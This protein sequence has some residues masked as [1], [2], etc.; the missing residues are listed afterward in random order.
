M[1]TGPPDAV[2][3]GTAGDG[4]ASA[5]RRVETALALA[6]LLGLVAGVYVCHDIVTRFR[7]SAAENQTWSTRRASYLSMHQHLADLIAPG[8]DIF[9]VRTD[10]RSRKFFTARAVLN[11]ALTDAR[12]EVAQNVPRA[13]A[14]PLA[15]LP[16]PTR[17]GIVLVDPATVTHAVLDGELVTIATT[18]G[19]YLSEA[20]LS[21]LQTRLA[22]DSFE[23]IKFKS[24]KEVREITGT[25]S[26]VFSIYSTGFVRA[27]KRETRMRIHTVVDFRA[28]PPPGEARTVDQLQDQA[29]TITDDTQR[30][31]AEQA[32]QAAL[33][34]SPAGNIVYYRMD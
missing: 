9:L 19:D 7:A 14:K 33:K 26:K 13:D 29:A 2:G 5:W 11:Q 15:R 4:A 1:H 16:I 17:Q 6:A 20:S 10:L 8:N 31:Q 24:P 18:N 23:P 22:G 30:A 32:I 3:D 28:A 21:D 27:G 12:R 34:P 25:E